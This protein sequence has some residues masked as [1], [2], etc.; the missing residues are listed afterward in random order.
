MPALSKKI[1]GI[2][3]NIASGKTMISSYLSNKGY[4]I[5][6]T[7]VIT[8]NI[9]VNDVYF[10]KELS[11]LLGPEIIKNDL[12][13]KHKVAQIV[14][15]DSKLLQSLNRIIH[16]LIK[17][18]TQT[19]INQSYGIV[20]VIVPLMFETDFYLLMDKIIMI[21]VTEKIQ[22]ERLMKRN[23]LSETQAWQRIRPQLKQDEKIRRADYVIDNSGDVTSLYRQVDF[24][25]AEIEAEHELS[26]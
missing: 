9:Y 7:D 5:I 14:F 18:E 26:A 11:R 23:N 10:R 20:F 22:L 21:K 17:K 8:E 15:S 4:V 3:G 12:I 19:Q 2:T 13:N 24:I 1:I 16:P 25:L 6:D